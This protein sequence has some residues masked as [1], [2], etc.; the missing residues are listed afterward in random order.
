MFAQIALNYKQ[1]EKHTKFNLSFSTYQVESNY[2]G[3]SI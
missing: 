1:Y 2:Y 3:N